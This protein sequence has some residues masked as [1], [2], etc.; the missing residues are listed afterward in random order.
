[1]KPTKPIVKMPVFVADVR[2]AAKGIAA[3]GVTIF[4]GIRRRY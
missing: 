2:R 1:L 3:T 4:V